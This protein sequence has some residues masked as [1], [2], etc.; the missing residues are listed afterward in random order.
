ML[1][2]LLGQAYQVIEEGLNGRT[3]IYT[4]IDEPYKNGESYL[5]PC[6]LTHKP[7]DAVVIMLGT[8]DLRMRFGVTKETLGEGIKKLVGIIQSTPQCGANQAPPKVLVVSPVHVIKPQGHMA[9]Y[10]DRGERRAEVL[11]QHFAATYQ[12]VADEMGCQ[13]LDAALFAPC[14]VADGLHLTAHSHEKL[15]KAIADKLLDMFMD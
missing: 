9:F 5:L 11:S 13:F 14:S 4:P 2:A 1:S 12:Q 7:I 15:A 3:T 8:N 6:L 10:E